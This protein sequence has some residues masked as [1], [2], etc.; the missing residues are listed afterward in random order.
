MSALGKLKSAVVLES[1]PINSIQACYKALDSIPA[2]DITAYG[3]AKPDEF[4][5]TTKRISVNG[6]KLQRASSNFNQGKWLTRIAAFSASQ[7]QNKIQVV[8]LGTCVGI[9]AMYMLAGMSSY[10][11]GHL[12]SFEGSSELAKLSSMH[13]DKFI[14][15]NKLDNISYEIVVGSLDDTLPAWLEKLDEKIDVAFIDGNHQEES[16]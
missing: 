10:N 14:E 2:F 12:T 7:T 9:S 16:T 5:V 11:G 13:I 4:D 6:R 1:Y 8:E 3:P 15:E